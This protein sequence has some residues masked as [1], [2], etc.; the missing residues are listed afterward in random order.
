MIRKVQISP[1]MELWLCCLT[2][3][4]NKIMER[5]FG[6]FCDYCRNEIMTILVE[7]GFRIQGF[8]NGKYTT[9]S[10]LAP[11]EEESGAAAGIV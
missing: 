1:R 5:D 2:R 6:T 3:L 8:T 11:T 10:A 9:I 4:L 7:M